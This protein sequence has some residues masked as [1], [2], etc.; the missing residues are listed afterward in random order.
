ML[1]CVPPWS[2][3][4]WPVTISF[5]ITAHA[6]IAEDRG[7]QTRGHID[8][9]YAG[10]I[11]RRAGLRVEHQT[12][13]IDQRVGQRRVGV[14]GRIDVGRLE[15]GVALDLER[16]IGAGGA[17]A[18]RD[19]AHEH[20]GVRAGL[21]QPQH[22]G[23]TRGCYG[24]SH[25]DRFDHVAVAVAVEIDHPARRSDHRR[26]RRGCPA[27]ESAAPDP[28]GHGP[29]AT[30]KPGGRSRWPHDTASG[31]RNCCWS[32][33]RRS[34]RARSPRATAA[35]ERQAGLRWKVWCARRRNRTGKRR[36]RRCEPP[37][38]AP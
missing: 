23:I 7:G 38:R 32:L 17:R 15:L 8:E 24:N 35:V 20:A 11:D 31:P 14:V 22:L 6:V 12:V 27:G 1:Y 19:V 34:A 16:A 10:A 33:P 4:V 36:L 30:A 21:R 26:A 13:R 25:I 3:T 18:G 2:V 28:E 9:P 29:A 37:F 5:G